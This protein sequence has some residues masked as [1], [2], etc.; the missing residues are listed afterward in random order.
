[1][2]ELVG[3]VSENK[4]GRQKV[5]ICSHFTVKVPHPRY[6]TLPEYKQLSKVMGLWCIFKTPNVRIQVVHFTDSFLQV[7]Q[8]RCKSCINSLWPSSDVIWHC[9]TWS[10]LVQVMA[11]HLFGDKP[12]HESMLT[13]CQMNSYEQTS[14]KTL[15]KNQIFSLK[16]MHFKMLPTRWWPFC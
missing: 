11:C 6:I 5:K 3:K 7:I 10:P 14:V 13:C 15:I 2:N 12:L 8:C 1:M 4:H 9:G 16:E